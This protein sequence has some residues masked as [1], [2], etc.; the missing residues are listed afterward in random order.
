MSSVIILGRFFHGLSFF[1]LGLTV[2]YLQYRSRRILLAR[3]LNWVG[4][5][6]ICEAAVAWY[7]LFVSLLPQAFTLPGLVRPVVLGVG[8]IFLIALGIQTFLAEETADNHGRHWLI[9]L[10]VL[11]VGGLLGAWLTWPAQRAAL[12]AW[13]NTFAHYLLGFPGGLLAA[14]GLRRQSHLTLD[15]TL[16]R[17]IR[18]SLRLVEI[19]AGIV[20]ILHVLLYLPTPA[21]LTPYHDVRLAITEW[22][23]VLIGAGLTLGLNRALNTVQLEIE[24]WI[25]GVERLQ[26]LAVDRERIGRDLHDGIIQSI[27]AAGLLLE[28]VQPV[29]P[30]NP[31][32]AQAQLGRVMDNLNETIQDIR[33]YIFDLRSDMPDDDLQSGIKRLLRDFHINTLLE[34]EFEVQGVPVEVLSMERRRHIFQV[35]RETLANTARHARARWV[36][37]V[38]QYNENT[39]DLTI[40]DDGVG[41]E[42]L[43]VSK[44]HG[45]RNIR[46]R[47]R[48][49]DGTLR[50]E[51]APNEGV[52]FH[53]TVPY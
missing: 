17:R 31:M 52:T 5:F 20:G 48:L 4:L 22:S 46:E 37:I 42:T 23:W 44:G 21:V 19:S 14:I 50:I 35:V 24:R 3:R 38:L 8:Y 10:N 11:W 36:K 41:M 34:T 2:F 33:R 1:T 7:D 16:R 40:S 26:A 30:I 13:G 53:L 49:L 27:Y 32:R 15:V 29:I 45:L 12:V 43:Q 39:L 9:A 28:S 51:S 47:A 25:E 6:A 18:T